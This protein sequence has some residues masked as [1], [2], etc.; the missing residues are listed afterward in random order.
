MEKRKKKKEKKFGSIYTFPKLI[1]ILVIG[2]KRKNL[3]LIMSGKWKKKKSPPKTSFNF[4]ILSIHISFQNR[5]EMKP[6]SY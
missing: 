2:L 3:K 4:G 5:N 1:L 6:I